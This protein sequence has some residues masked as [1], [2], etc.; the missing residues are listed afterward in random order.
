MDGGWFLAILLLILLLFYPQSVTPSPNFVFC[1]RAPLNS[2]PPGLLRRLARLPDS[3]GGVDPGHR[4]PA[5][6]EAEWAGLL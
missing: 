1:L 2:V 4:R 5:P 3:L 6:A